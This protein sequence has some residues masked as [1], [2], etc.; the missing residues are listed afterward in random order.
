MFELN[1]V[2]YSIEQLQNAA[3]KYGMDF[4]MYI[5]KMKEKGLVEKQAGSAGDPTMGQES[6]GSNL[7][8]GSSGS[9]GWFEQALQAGRVN[10]DLY[11]DADAIFDVSSS[12]EV[13][14]LSD[15]QLKAIYH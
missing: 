11:D 10:A 7:E 1:G 12:T 15:D 5:E 6:M 9:S 8:T 14:S 4:E 13:A 2:N 3:D